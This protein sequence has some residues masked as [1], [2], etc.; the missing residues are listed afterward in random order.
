MNL[1][2]SSICF[3]YLS[4]TLGALGRIDKCKL[5]R[6][7]APRVP[8][9]CGEFTLV[10]Y[11]CLPYLFPTLVVLGRMS[12][13]LSPTLVWY[14]GCLGPHEFTLVSNLSPTLVAHSG[15]LRPHDFTLISQL[16]PKR[17]SPTLDVLERIDK[18]KLMRPK[19]PRVGD[20]CGRQVWETSVGDKWKTSVNSCSPRHPECE[21]SVGDKC[22]LMRP[23]ATRVGDKCG[24]QMETSVNSCGPRHP[25]WETSVGDKWEDKCKL[26]R[27]K[28]PKCEG[29]VGDKCKIIRPKTPRLGDKCG[30]QV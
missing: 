13:H 4:P 9:K 14:S 6:P 18:C 30:R 5:M 10:S 23:K 17:E 1:H 15:C 7:K 12:L 19:A 3:P 11:T 27:P 29:Q 24:R 8:D 26:M 2:L 22:K 20:K 28:A 25:E 21:T 16:F